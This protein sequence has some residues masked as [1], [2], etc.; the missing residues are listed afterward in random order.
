M[1]KKKKAS[2]DQPTTIAPAGSGDVKVS[3]HPRARRSIRKAKG[4]GGLAGFFLVAWFSWHAG[5]DFPH[6][7]LRSIGAG[8]A[9]YVVAWTAAV[10]IW[11][12]L[13]IAEIRQRARLLALK[14]LAAEEA[15]AGEH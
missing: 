3:E 11:R 1:A 5:T 13:A 2:E 10:Y 4:Y 12:Q 8:L 6:L 15:S 9:G 7:A 14:K